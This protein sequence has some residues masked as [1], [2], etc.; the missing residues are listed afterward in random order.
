MRSHCLLGLVLLGVFPLDTYAFQIA[1]DS[2][3][4]LAYQSESGGAWK[5]LNP[6][7]AE[8]P[9]GSDNGGYGFSPWNFAGGYHKT[10]ARSF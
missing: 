7:A 2:A 9:P 8:N 5:G 6:T 1:I 4:P 3:E 10:S